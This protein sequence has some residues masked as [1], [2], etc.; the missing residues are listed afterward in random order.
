MEERKNVSKLP[1]VSSYKGTNLIMRAPPPSP[2][3]NKPKCIPKAPSPGITTLGV[4]AFRYEFGGKIIQS[5]APISKTK[6]DH[7]FRNYDH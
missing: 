6:R 5:I 2:Y 7:H 1:A 4:R 3:L